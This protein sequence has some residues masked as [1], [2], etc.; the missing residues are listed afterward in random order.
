[1]REK[2][3]VG[4][5]DE[6]EKLLMALRAAKV[7]FEKIRTVL[8]QTRSIEALQSR[9]WKLANPDLYVQKIAKQE[10]YNKNRYDRIRNGTA[11]GYHAQE[12]PEDVRFGPRQ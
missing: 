8:S 6:D 11:Y 3:L 7:P 9:V 1:M 12:W 4:W 10:I 2:R 5:T